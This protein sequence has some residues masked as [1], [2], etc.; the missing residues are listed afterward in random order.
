MERLKIEDWPNRLEAVLASD[1][2]LFRKVTV[3]RETDSTQSAARRLH[4]KGGTVIIAG[5]QTTGRGRLGRQ[6]ADTADHGTACTFVVDAVMTPL[7]EQLPIAAAVGVADT[8]EALLGR[9]VKIKWPNDILISDRK[10]SGILIEREPETALIGV[11]INVLQES[12]PEELAEVAVSLAQL[13]CE[14]ERV[15]VLEALLRHFD[16]ALRMEPEEI[17]SQ[18]LARDVL[19]GTTRSFRCDNRVVTGKVERLDPMHGLIVRDSSGQEIWLPAATTT[20]HVESPS[21]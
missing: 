20:L 13:G 3:L 21:D 9:A 7:T 16:E 12:W 2:K 17:A 6:W 8:I 1:C 19:V 14:V 4:A 11:G 15:E 10:L 18:F 5:R